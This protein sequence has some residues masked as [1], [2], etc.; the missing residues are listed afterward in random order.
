MKKN[1]L[2]LLFL[3]MNIGLFAQDW[4]PINTSEKFCY[5]SDS[6]IQIIN[7]VLWVDSTK[8]MSD[9]EIYYFNKVVSSCD[10]CSEPNYMLSHQP[11]FLLDQAKAYENGEWFFESY[12]QQ[13]KILPDAQLNGEWLFDEENSITAQIYSNEYVEVFGA[14]DSLKL[15]S[16]SNGKMFTLSKNHGI[17][18]WL[19]EAQL[20]GIEGRDLGVIVPKFEDMFSQVE[21]ADVVCYFTYSA[22]QWKNWEYRHNHLRYEVTGI[23]KSPDSVVLEAHYYRKYSES[24]YGQVYEVTSGDTVLVFYPNTLTEAYPNELIGGIDYYISQI[25]YDNWGGLTKTNLS[26]SPGSG[27]SITTYEPDNQFPYL[28]KPIGFYD[29]SKYSFSVAVGFMERD[30]DG[31]EWEDDNQVVGYI[32]NGISHGEI[33]S[34]DMFVGQEELSS[35]NFLVYPSPANEFL[36][37]QTKEAGEIQFQ[38]FNIS[39]QLVLDGKQEKTSADVD[40]DIS[41]LQNGVYIIQMN[42]GQKLIQNKFIKQN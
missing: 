20:I 11:Q 28:L 22:S 26:T 37:I 19:G 31:F 16:L 35:N 17:L 1:L 2:L 40:I 39:G 29:Y 23:E 12:N 32:H 30:I 34:V 41:E 36:K 15:V 33:Y 8:Q 10:T 13:F 14:F 18:E 4:E 27:E 5:S 9:H 21:E 24:E 3:V 7:H 38:V 6:D 42:L 25:D